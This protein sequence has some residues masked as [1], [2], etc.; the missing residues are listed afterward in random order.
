MSHIYTDE[1]FI[2]EMANV[3]MD[4]VRKRFNVAVNS[5]LDDELYGEIHGAIKALHREVVKA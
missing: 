3:V 5:N 2:D 1:E 4:V